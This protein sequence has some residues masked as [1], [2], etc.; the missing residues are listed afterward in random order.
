MIRLEFGIVD[1]GCLI[2]ELK[3]MGDLTYHQG[4]ST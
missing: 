2:E 3:D 4:S 1:R